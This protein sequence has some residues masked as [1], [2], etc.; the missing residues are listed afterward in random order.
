ML[1]LFMI[2][3][4]CAGF[5]KP[6]RSYKGEAFDAEKWQNGDVITRGNMSRALVGVATLTEQAGKDKVELLKNLGEPFS[7]REDTIGDKKATVLIYEVDLGTPEFVDA[8]QIFLDEDD[9]PIFANHS[10]IR[11]KQSLIERI[12][13]L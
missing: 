3:A 4:G 5:K 10:V 6:W 12:K 7:I 1:F 8:L 11:E 2:S 13:S 9:K